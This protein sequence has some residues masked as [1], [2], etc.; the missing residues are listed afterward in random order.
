ME[1]FEVIENR[2]IKGGESPQTIA[3]MKKEHDNQKNETLGC[4]DPQACNYEP[5][6]NLD[7]NS[8]CLSWIAK[9]RSRF[10]WLSNARKNGFLLRQVVTVGLVTP[11]V[12][13]IS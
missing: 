2:A 13:E 4:T 5:D 6:A 10:I 3:L 1:S 7:N 8:C 9:I 11:N 12:K